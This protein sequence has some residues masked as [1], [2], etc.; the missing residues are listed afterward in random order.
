[1]IVAGWFL[2]YAEDS[3]GERAESGWIKAEVSSLLIASRPLPSDY[4]ISVKCLL[5]EDSELALHITLAL[6]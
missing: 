4:C 3:Y 6:V 5:V 2:S 1:M